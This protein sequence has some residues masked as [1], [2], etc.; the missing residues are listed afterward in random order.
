MSDHIKVSVCMITYNHGQYLEQAI[1][2][3]LRQKTAFKFELI[4][5]ND[6]SPDNTDQLVKKLIKTNANPKCEIVYISHEKNVGSALNAESVF[7]SARG[8]YM[9]LC[10]GDDFW[11]D[12]A[13]LQQQVDAMENNP[14]ATVCF[15]AVTVVNSTGEPISESR[16]SPGIQPSFKAL[17][18]ENFIHTPSVMYRILF[19]PISLVWMRGLIVGDWILHLRHAEKGDVIYINKVMASYRM[20]SGGLW[21]MINENARL[22]KWITVVDAVTVH[23]F[24]QQALGLNYTKKNCLFTLSANHFKAFQL[25]AGFKYLYQALVL[26]TDPP[27]TLVSI[28][29]RLLKRLIKITFSKKNS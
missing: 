19:K 10:E 3:V 22:L 23:L 6:C 21:S 12:T 7:D 13:K 29:K 16:L 8:Q 17:L 15:H 26:K 28:L 25:S 14:A 9:A 11:Q 5:G 18:K 27:M 20:H 4:V 24:P 1:L 2:G